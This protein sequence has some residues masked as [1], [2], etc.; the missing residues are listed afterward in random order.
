MKIMID[1]GHGYSTPGKRTIDGS[2]REWEFNSVVSNYVKETLSQYQGIDVLFAHDPTGK[3]DISLDKRTTYANQA[4]VDVYVSI[5]A[6]AF[7]SGWNTANGIETFVY[8]SNPQVARNLANL[9]QKKLV[10]YTKRSNR[11]VKTADFHVLRE[12]HMTAIL[13]ECGFMTNKEE[14]EL[15]KSDS[16]RRKCAQAIAEALIEFYNLKAKPQ[17]KKPAEP[18]KKGLYKVQVG[19]FSE[20]ANAERLAAKLK[21]EGYDVM[22]VQV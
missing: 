11:G 6:N 16:Y 19:A 9:T 2:M 1:G 15:L 3:I 13:V 4:G 20:E 14:A 7:G 12:T 22:I 21:S 17:P 5:H 18:T 8:K 10:E